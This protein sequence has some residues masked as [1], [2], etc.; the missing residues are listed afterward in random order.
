MTWDAPHARL[1][2]RDREHLS[3][4]LAPVARVSSR[5]PPTAST[6]HTRPRSR[7]A[8]ITGCSGPSTAWPMARKNFQA[9][10]LSAGRV[11]ERLG[12]YG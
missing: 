2:G 8:A 5:N 12:I 6:T 11:P 9:G 3:A 1:V 7:S 4:P 10:T